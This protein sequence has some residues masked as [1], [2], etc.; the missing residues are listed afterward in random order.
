MPV[1][2]KLRE[3]IDFLETGH[4]QP[5][6]LTFGLADQIFLPK[7]YLRGVGLV[8]KFHQ[9]PFIPSKV[10]QLF[11][12]DRHTDRH[13]NPHGRGKFFM[14]VFNTFHFTTFV[15]DKFAFFLDSFFY[16]LKMISLNF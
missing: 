10:I 11:N 13:T 14:P 15:K 5:R 6:A 8:L 9:N 3:E 1:G 16:F 4:F 12:L 2:Q 7:N